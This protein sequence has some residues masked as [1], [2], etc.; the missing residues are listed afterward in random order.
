MRVSQPGPV[1]SQHTGTALFVRIPRWQLD[2]SKTRQKQSVI[3]TVY[4]F[5]MNI[6]ATLSPVTA[7]SLR[8]DT[9][10]N[11]LTLEEYW[12]LTH[13]VSALEILMRD[14]KR[15]ERSKDCGH[16]SPAALHSV[17]MPS[18]SRSC[19]HQLPSLTASCPQKK[20]LENM[21]ASIAEHIKTRRERE[22]EE[23][24]LLVAR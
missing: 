19:Y 5:Y 21:K 11:I 23:E 15:T 20:L 14:D 18:K 4:S 3:I 13:S 12:L 16:I 17:H 1:V 8:V 22:L 10:L 9:G 6:M 7:P 24:N 2:W